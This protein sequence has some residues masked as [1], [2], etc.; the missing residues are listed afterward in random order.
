MKIDYGSVFSRAWNITWK[1]KILWIFGF[2]AM[3]GGGSS[4]SSG[5]NGGGGSNNYRGNT[6][7][8]PQP[9]GFGE[10]AGMP[11]ALSNLVYQLQHI[12]TTTIVLIV[13]GVCLCLF[14]LWL[15]VQ[16]LAILGTGGLIGGIDRVDATSAVTFGEA[17]GI[18]RRYF[19][20]LLLLRLMR[21]LVGL[22]VGLMLF[23]PIICCCPLGILLSIFVGFV[24]SYAFSF[25]DIAVVVENKSVGESIERAYTLLRDNFGPTF[26]VALIL[27][28][29]SL[30]I[31][32]ASLVL[33]LPFIGFLAAALWPVFTATGTLIMPLLITALV[34]LVLGILAC[35]VVE[36]V[37]T[38]YRVTVI[39]LAYKH[40]AA[41]PVVAPALTGNPSAPAAIGP[42]V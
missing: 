42:T 8:F 30:G 29:I 4:G 7:N 34:F 41:N 23:I 27:F 37:W 2:L 36:S 21:I 16:I 40:F 15:V 20:R 1:H 5:F 11:P 33:I 39:V 38:T 22:V 31:G 17:W 12:D 18:G 28:A 25:M 3:L 24:V 10:G 32:I 35:L 9:S 6:G 19:W 14:L 26:I 13:V